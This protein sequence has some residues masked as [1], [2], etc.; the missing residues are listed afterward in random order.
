MSAAQSTPA[1]WQEG[2]CRVPMWQGG[3]P[4]GFCGKLAHGHQ[5]PERLLE[6]TRVR[7]GPSPYCFG[8]CCLMHGGPR[9]GEPIVFQDGLTPEGRPMWC[10]VMPGFVDLQVS[11]SGFSGNP[12]QA[13]ANL[14]ADAA[15]AQGAQQ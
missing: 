5:L 3:A 2:Q 12:M 6:E 13:V 1:A 4:S 15:R 9:A 11:A 10:A 14:H 8:H 7:P